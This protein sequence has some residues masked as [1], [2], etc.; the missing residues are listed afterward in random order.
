MIRYRPAYYHTWPNDTLYGSTSFQLS[1][2]R[3]PVLSLSPCSGPRWLWRRPTPLHLRVKRSIK[4]IIILARFRGFSNFP[5]TGFWN[6]QHWYLRGW[7]SCTKYVPHIFAQFTL[8]NFKLK[9]GLSEDTSPGDFP[10]VYRISWLIL[11]STEP[12]M[13]TASSNFIPNCDKQISSIFLEWD[14]AYSIEVGLS[15]DITYN[16]SGKIYMRTTIFSNYHRETRLT[17]N[18]TRWPIVLVVRL[19]WPWKNDFCSCKMNQ[20]VVLC[21]RGVP[22]LPLKAAL[23]N[24]VRTAM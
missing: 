14:H 21:S 7:V 22:R 2:P 23:K 4:E 19:Y 24:N 16:R 10:E 9:S 18:K 8:L 12:T 20:Y 1:R 6:W 15:L 11:E 5:E 13:Q 17:G 3:L